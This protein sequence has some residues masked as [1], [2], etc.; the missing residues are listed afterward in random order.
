MRLRRCYHGFYNKCYQPQGKPH[1]TTLHDFQNVL[2]ARIMQC[3]S[4]NTLSQV[5]INTTLLF[6]LPKYPC[7]FGHAMKRETKGANLLS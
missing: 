4:K 2:E 6:D 7:Y 3:H 1:P 5:D